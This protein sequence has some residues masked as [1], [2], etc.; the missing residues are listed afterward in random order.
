MG[1]RCELYFPHAG[2]VFWMFSPQRIDRL[3][4]AG[5]DVIAGEMGGGEGEGIGE[6]GQS[7]PHI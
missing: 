5:F 6:I 1:V 2:L 7:E 4:S 3:R